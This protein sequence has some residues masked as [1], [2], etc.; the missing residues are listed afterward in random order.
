MSKFIRVSEAPATLQKGEYVIEMPTFLEEVN[1]PR[2]RKP[3]NR[4]TAIH[5]L[6]AISELIGSKYDPTFNTYH[7]IRMAYYVDRPFAT[8]EDLS[9]IVVEMFEKEYPQIFYSYIDYKIK[10]RPPSTKLVYFVGTHE[11]SKVF[12]SNGLDFI[13]ELPVTEEPKKAKAK[14]A[15]TEPTE[16]TTKTEGV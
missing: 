9:K 13:N 11:Y 14:K 8:S 5:M 2:I 3:A 1:D 4:K 16:L 12:L 6:R 10:N 7:T 15:E